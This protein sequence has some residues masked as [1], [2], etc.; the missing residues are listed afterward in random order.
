MEW[1]NKMNDAIDYIEENLAHD[2][3][4]EKAAKIACFSTYHFQRLFSSII[5]VPLS[6]YIRRRRLTLAAFDI[7]TSD[8]K[9]ID[10]AYKYGYESP[11]AFSRAFKKLHGVMPISARASGVS[12][13]TFPRVTF[14]ISIKGDK[15]M[16][17]RIEKREAFE[18]FGKY[19]EVSIVHEKAFEQVPKFCN[20]CD[21]DGTV[22]TINQVLGRFN[23]T[24]TMSALF[25]YG[26]STFKYMLCN[27]LPPDLKVPA[28]FTKLSVPSH[29][30]VIFDVPNGEMQT[31]WK[32]IFTEW[33]PT[34]EYE[35][36]EGIQFEMYYGLAKHQNG[37]GE[38]W[39]P[40]KKK[41]S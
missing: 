22:A 8:I 11:E 37:F 20:Q 16:N 10:V 24:Y 26:E 18:V 6:E 7:Q 32:R 23:D 5:E 14:S 33:F 1:L 31:L 3:S 2:I 30:W 39:V 4:F 21:E 34:S 17:Y 41:V 35:A 25:D 19:E 27:Y 36:V 38:I 15:E 28:E 9:I 13:K 12:L 29:M 40:V